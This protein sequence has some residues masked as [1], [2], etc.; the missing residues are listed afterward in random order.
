LCDYTDDRRNLPSGRSHAAG[1]LRLL[2]SL[3]QNPDVLV[4]QWFSVPV[5][6]DHAP[7]HG[8][9]ITGLN[10]GLD[11]LLLE[12]RSANVVL[13]KRHC[14]HTKPGCSSNCVGNGTTGRPAHCLTRPK[15]R[16]TRTIN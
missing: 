11:G 3:N 8:G 1:V 14:G 4:L 15:E 12:R 2:Q 5:I 16:L 6:G 9:G 10:P 13:I 7:A